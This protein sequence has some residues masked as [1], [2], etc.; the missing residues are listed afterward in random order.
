VRAFQQQLKA[1]DVAGITDLFAEDGFWRDLLI[2]E[3]DFN[4]LAS[5]YGECGQR[6]LIPRA[7]ADI[8]KHLKRCG[9]PEI[10]KL[11]VVRPFDA[12]I[13]GDLWAQYASARL[14]PNL[15]SPRYRAFFK[16]ETPKLIGHGVVRV[17]S[18]GGKFEK[19]L[20]CF[21]A[22]DAVKGHEEL[23][24]DRRPNGSEV[25][26]GG[27]HALNWLEQRQQELEFKVEQPT[28]LM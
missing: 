5:A 7:E 24:G 4:T 23:I 11:K 14:P 15:S 12:S 20:T 8:P 25:H 28:V 22:V 27:P 19:A 18:D 2:L 6:Q 13:V 16:F 10:T 26:S 9:V 21:T 17:K 3:Q 1:K